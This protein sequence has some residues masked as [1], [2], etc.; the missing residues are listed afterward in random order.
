MH[1]GIHQPSFRRRDGTM[2]DICCG[3]P[4]ADRTGTAAHHG[5]YETSFFI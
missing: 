1:I 4:V 3:V 5:R 2:V